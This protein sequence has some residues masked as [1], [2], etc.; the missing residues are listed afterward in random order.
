MKKRQFI[1]QMTATTLG[2]GLAPALMVSACQTGSQQHT[3]EVKTGDGIWMDLPELPYDHAALEPAIDATTMHIHHGKHHQ[4]YLNKLKAALGDQKYDSFQA[5]FAQDPL[6]ESLRNNGGGHFNHSLFWESLAPHAK[7]PSTAFE[8]SIKQYFGSM[9]GLKEAL[10][11]GG[12]SIFG[13]GWVWLIKDRKGQLSITTTA[14]QDNPLMA[15]AIAQGRP[16]L[17]IDVWEH[18]Y[19]LKY[20]NKRGDY[21]HNILEIINWQVV[22]ARV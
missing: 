20:Q 22:G 17:G 12:T 15:T 10:I 3:L 4:G 6:P 13:S 5:L 9:E 16:L 18:A 8:Q 21:L 2:V 1:K 14:N 19:Y 11:D 7:A